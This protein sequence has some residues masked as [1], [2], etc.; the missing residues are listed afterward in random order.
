MARIEARWLPARLGVPVARAAVCVPAASLSN[1]RTDC[2][3]TYCHKQRSQVNTPRALFC[4]PCQIPASRDLKQ[5]L[6]RDPFAPLPA[7]LGPQ[8]ALLALPV[9]LAAA[10]S[11][12]RVG[13]S[14]AHA[15]AAG[16]RVRVTRSN[17]RPPAILQRRRSTPDRCSLGALPTSQ[18]RPAPRCGSRAAPRCPG[19]THPRPA[20]RCRWRFRSGCRPRHGLDSRSGHQPRSLGTQPPSW[21][22]RSGDRAAQ[23]PVSRPSNPF[24]APISVR[25]ALDRPVR[26]FSL[27]REP[28]SAPPAGTPPVAAPSPQGPIDPSPHPPS[29][30]HRGPAGAGTVPRVHPHRNLAVEKIGRTRPVA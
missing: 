19:G 20:M 16:C 15:S 27:A 3:N 8:A 11:S 10:L 18:T 2:Y 1:P 28:S 6:K 7:H 12:A 26:P 4:T 5:P 9:L 13:V 17:P 23:P 25:S 21:P 14:F 29:G 24:G 22:A 30:S